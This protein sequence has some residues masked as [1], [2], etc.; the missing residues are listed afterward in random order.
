MP[1]SRVSVA[2][3]EQ[4]HVPTADRVTRVFSGV[5]DVLAEEESGSEEEEQL[6]QI[7][8]SEIC[9]LQAEVDAAAARKPESELQEE[10]TV[11]E[12]KFTGFYVDTKPSAVVE[13]LRHAQTVETALGDIEEE[14]IV[15]VAPHPRAGPA[16][17]PPPEKAAGIAPY[18][19]IL[20]GIRSDP[21][22]GNERAEATDAVP[23]PT[24]EQHG[25]EE[26]SVSSI[27]MN[28]GVPAP[29]AEQSGSA[30]LEGTTDAQSEP[31][32]A[33]APQLAAV[34]SFEEVSFSFTSKQTQKKLIRKAHPVR[35]P[36]ALL[37]KTPN[38]RKAIRRFGTFGASLEEAHLHED[39]Q[40]SRAAHRRRGDSDLDWGDGSEAGDGVD[41]LSTGIGA[42][43]IDPDIDMRAMA[44]FVK[45]M[46]AAGSSFVTMDD[47]ADAEAMKAEDEDED[48]RRS[49]S[50]EEAAQ[51]SE[52]SEVDA[53]VRLEEE[54]LIPEQI[55]A[56]GEDVA[57]DSSGED[58]EDE[59][60]SDDEETPRRGFQ[61]RLER[62]RKNS[63]GKKK[64]SKADLSSD[65]DDSD[66][67]MALNDPWADD[68]EDYIAHI[69]VSAKNERE[70]TI[71]TL[72]QR[73]WSTPMRT[74]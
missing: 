57:E 19:S 58:E 41:E 48:E 42:M 27:A 29:R 8:F 34:P 9:R 63:K 43:E 16:T 3:D 49:E 47:I 2:N 13:T 66:A 28:N 10:V 40:D 65:E 55:V 45:S 18:T 37:R 21:S 36:K 39:E 6:E 64:A 11:V 1:A 59:E 71:L 62:I 68:D 31:R 52:D 17:P 12:E 50:T 20:S 60:S 56:S 14:V 51:S 69:Q 54:Q 70:Q 32:G 5:P 33:G 22:N 25:E 61:A 4:S 38:R 26:R 72:I 46:S 24:A 44:S 73:L 53:V 35:T 23:P 30:L 7:D 67:E 74:C 15:Y